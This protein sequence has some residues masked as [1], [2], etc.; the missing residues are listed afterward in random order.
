V[1]SLCWDKDKWDEKALTN[2]DEKIEVDGEGLNTL[3][4]EVIRLQNLVALTDEVFTRIG[5]MEI[6]DD[7]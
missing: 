7:E 4:V 1:L 3:I 2:L 6:S 5:V